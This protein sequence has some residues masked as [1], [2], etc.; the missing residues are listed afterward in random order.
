MSFFLHWLPSL[1]AAAVLLVAALLLDL[2]IR[3]DERRASA[4]AP[5][6]GDRASVR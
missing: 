2:S 3:R 4:Q 1:I 6:A 5:P